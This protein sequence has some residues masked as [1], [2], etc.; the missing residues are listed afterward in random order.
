MKYFRESMLFTQI[1][2]NKSFSD[3]KKSNKHL[4]NCL[5][6]DEISIS[7]E[8]EK[9]IQSEVLQSIVKN[10]AFLIQFIIT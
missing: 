8:L 3:T 9:K 5:V 10:D 6:L 7:L 2:E 4:L 1:N